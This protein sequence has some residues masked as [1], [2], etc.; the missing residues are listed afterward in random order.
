MAEIRGLFDSASKKKP[1]RMPDGIQAVKRV[2]RNM[3]DDLK[4][5]RDGKIEQHRR[6]NK[7]AKRKRDKLKSR[8]VQVE[9]DTY[10]TKEEKRSIRKAFTVES[11]SP[12]VTDDEDE[13]RRVS[14]PFQWESSKMTEIKREMDKDYR[15]ALTAQSRRQKASVNRSST[16]VM[17]TSPPKDIPS[18]AVSSTY[19]G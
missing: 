18:W 5:K 12:E 15:K 1:L 2:W 7:E 13:T 17:R 16:Q 19:Q 6:K 11:M 9:R 14:I 3:R 8:L 4:R 10:F